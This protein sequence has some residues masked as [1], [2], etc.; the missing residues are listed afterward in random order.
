MQALVEQ[1]TGRALALFSDDTEVHFEGA[2][3][4][5]PKMRFANT[6]PETHRLLKTPPLAAPLVFVAGAMAFD[7][8]WSIYDQETYDRFSPDVISREGLEAAEKRAA[9]LAKAE[10]DIRAERDRRLNLDFEFQGKTYQRDGKSLRRITG[11]STLAGFAVAVG[12]PVGNLLWHSPEDGVSEFGWI[13][14]DDSITPMDAQTCFA[15]GQAA[16]AVESNLVF[17]AKY[18]RE[19]DPIPADIADDK[20]WPA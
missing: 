13:A 8:A 14:S 5:A 16:A 7:G 19:M 10:K 3:C 17:A 1:S 4:V 12:S 11:A 18:L 9:D 20:H 2:D 15:F 6:P